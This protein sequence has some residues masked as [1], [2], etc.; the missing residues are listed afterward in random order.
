MSCFHEHSCGRAQYKSNECLLAW[1]IDWIKHLRTLVQYCVLQTCPWHEGR[2]ILRGRE[3][4][5]TYRNNIQRCSSTCTLFRFGYRRRSIYA[6]GRSKF[7]RKNYAHAKWHALLRRLY[8]AVPCCSRH[9]WDNL[10]GSWGW[11][12]S[13]EFQWCLYPHK[14]E[15]LSNRV[16]NHRIL[17]RSCF[18]MLWFYINHIILQIRWMIQGTHGL[19][20]SAW[21][22]GLVKVLHMQCICTAKDQFWHHV[23]ST[24]TGSA[25]RTY[26]WTINQAM[27]VKWKDSL[28]YCVYM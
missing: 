11:W 28:L 5:F 19:W 3:R 20:R 1:F 24:T 15:R 10:L 2:D 12:L 4:I 25:I 14:T 22:C 16:T 17:I 27:L 9:C 26:L 7:Q 13:R 8:F 21:T 6:M 23:C 18:G